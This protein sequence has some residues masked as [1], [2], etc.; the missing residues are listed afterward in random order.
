[1]LL[2]NSFRHVVIM[3]IFVIQPHPLPC[4]KFNDYRMNRRSIPNENQRPKPPVLLKPTQYESLATLPSQGVYDMEHTGRSSNTEEDHS[5]MHHKGSV[6]NMEDEFSQEFS[7]IHNPI[8][9]GDNKF[10]SE[11]STIHVD[12]NGDNEFSSEFSIIH[13]N[14][15]LNNEFSSEFSTIH[16]TGNGDNEFLSEFSTINDTGNVENK[17][18]S[19]FSARLYNQNLSMA[20]G[21]GE[22]SSGFST[23]PTETGTGESHLLN[24]EVAEAER[25]QQSLLTSNGSSIK[26]PSL[27]K[28]EIKYVLSIQ[29]LTAYLTGESPNDYSEFINDNLINFVNENAYCR[30]YDLS[31]NFVCL[32]QKLMQYIRYLS[33]HKALKLTDTVNQV[34]YP[35]AKMRYVSNN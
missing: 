1:M 2:S 15:N 34:S 21:S 14:G 8:V 19:E 16:D 31:V 11:F 27:K 6:G 24:N 17:F 7:T 28:N 29:N 23:V 30:G 12:G 26:T 9:N 35:V 20:N 33:S 32:K 5:I 4:S 22:F 25:I 13:D 18:S 10:S 3:F